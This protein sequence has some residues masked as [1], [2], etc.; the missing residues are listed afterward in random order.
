MAEDYP[1][2]IKN[3]NDKPTSSK[4]L[5]TYNQ[6]IYTHINYISTYYHDISEN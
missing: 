6:E 1:N 3:K 5:M 4:S 2:L